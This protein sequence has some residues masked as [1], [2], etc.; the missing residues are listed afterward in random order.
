MKKKSLENWVLGSM[1]EG[2][3]HTDEQAVDAEKGL[4]SNGERN[5]Y[6][7]R[8]SPLHHNLIFAVSYLTFQL[9]LQ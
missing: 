8:S 5:F 9:L 3:L 1:R 6:A 2:P 4:L 7:D